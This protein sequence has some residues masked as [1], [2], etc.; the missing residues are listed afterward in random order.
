MILNYIIFIYFDVKE[1]MIIIG[2]IFVCDCKL[3]YK[4]Y[5]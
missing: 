4:F 1:Y 2:K 3:V 5:V